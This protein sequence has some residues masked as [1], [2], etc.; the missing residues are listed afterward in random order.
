MPSALPMFI[1]NSRA[2]NRGVGLIEGTR[3]PSIAFE[4][5]VA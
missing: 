3:C 2:A 4:W 5:A 1:Y